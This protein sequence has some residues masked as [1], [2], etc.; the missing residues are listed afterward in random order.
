MLTWMNDRT[1][2][3]YLVG[4]C[5]DIGKLPPEFTRAERLDAIYFLDLPT[6]EQR[7]AIWDIY[8]PM[9]GLDPQQPRP[10]DDNYTGAEIRSC[11]RLAALLDVPLTAASQNVVPVAVTAAESV[12]RL[13]QWASGRCLDAAKTGIFQR[14]VD[15]KRRRKIS[16]DPSSN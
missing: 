10:E 7:K 9:F 13:R 16:A 3:V 4:T 8:I 1:S 14:A 6:P 15:T 2:D 5:N 11:C 12:E